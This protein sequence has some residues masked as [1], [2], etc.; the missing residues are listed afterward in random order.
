[1]PRQI[2]PSSPHKLDVAIGQRIRQ[3]RR[4]LGLP[5]T[6]LAEMVGV[7]FQQIQKYERGANRISFS[8]LVE[9]AAALKCQLTDLTE[10]LDAAA[11]PSNLAYLN[12]LLAH[13]GALDMLEAYVALPDP[14]LRRAVLQHARALAGASKGPALSTGV[15]TR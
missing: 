14:V 7:T 1:M 15:K 6:A 11:P 2:V 12:E 4:A 13:P 3:R 9:I 5:Q 10:G 8:R